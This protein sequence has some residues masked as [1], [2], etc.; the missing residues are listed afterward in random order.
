MRICRI[1]IETL[2]NMNALKSWVRKHENDSS[3][4]RGK[5]R[6]LLVRKKIVWSGRI[7][8]C[9]KF[10]GGG[11]R[12]FSHGLEPA[13]NCPLQCRTAIGLDQQDDESAT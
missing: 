11:E 10:T 1:W 13:S 5:L 2:T 6:L 9:R 3:R 8:G 7:G 4:N 12:W